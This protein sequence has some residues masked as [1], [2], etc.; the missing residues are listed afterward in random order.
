MEYKDF[1]EKIG[2]ARKD[3]WSSRGLY[4]ADLDEMND[5]ETEKFVK[6]DYIWKN[7]DYQSLI[8]N[9]MPR[10][11]AYFIKTVRDSLY[12]SP[13]YYTTDNTPEKKLARQK[14]YVDTVREIQTVVEKVRTRYE[15]MLAFR[16][17]LIEG[18]YIKHVRGN[19]RD[20]L[21]A[22]D[23]GRENPNIT[24]KLVNALY[25]RS[26]EDYERKIVR[27]ASRK[28][29]GVPASKKDP[30]KTTA[31]KKRFVPEQLKDV[32]RTG[33]DLRHGQDVTGQ[34]YLDAFGF[35]GG[36]YGNWMNQDDRR[37][38]MNMG[39]DALK[40]LAG[41]L[42]ISEKDISFRETLSI[43]FGAR[44]RGNAVAHYE[45]LRKVIN[46]TK[47]RGAGSLAHE[48]W[49]GL[50]DYLGTAMGADTLLSERARR[51]EPMRKLLDTIK[52]K[53]VMK[54]YNSEQ[55]SARKE[56]IRA[57][58]GNLL[59]SSMLYPLERH[60]SEDDMAAYNSLKEAFLSGKPG[61]VEQISA[62]RKKACGRVIPKQERERLAIYERL[63][64][65][66]A[67]PSQ[68][69]EVK[70]KTDYYRNSILMGKECRKDGGYW[71][72]NTELTAR[73]FACYV[74]DRLPYIS[75]YLAGHAESA[76]T[77]VTGK[78]GEPGVLKAYPEG[79]ERAA[80]DAVFDEFFQCLK[81]D[82]YLTHSDE[83]PGELK[84]QRSGQKGGQRVDNVHQM[85]TQMSSGTSTPKSGILSS[86]M[87]S[88]MS[89]DMSTQMSTDMSASMS[90]LEVGQARQMS[91]MDF[92]L[93][94]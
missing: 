37:E 78:D 40:D 84:R 47:M 4:S 49:H 27:E 67:S 5:R 44:G 2:G 1:G 73:A 9:G 35:R 76:V 66:N 58:A 42:H 30:G 52:Y 86:Q 23:K 7:P 69:R 57:T 92:G 45:P 59:D 34:D 71:D 48:W 85:S 46:L 20:F 91:L 13:R 8:D 26:E 14:E 55:E 16:D 19:Y 6:K 28:G 43:A 74:K 54:E 51:Y 21:T 89:T 75:D 15:A 24:N 17:I 32:R 81:K 88:R 83:R 79:E 29:F 80:I 53:M 61:T 33:P 36:E 10:D 11:V 70:T 64:A 50:D 31:G 62:L 25:F 93:I 38:S 94:G 60:G 56:Q 63:M 18:G 72:S 3:L 90:T 12:A 39:F 77:L 41:V 65:L 87:S 68:P 82:G 22:T